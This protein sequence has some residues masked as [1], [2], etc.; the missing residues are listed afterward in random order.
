MRRPRKSG[1]DLTFQNKSKEGIRIRRK[2]RRKL[3]HGSQPEGDWPRSKEKGE[4][5]EPKK[6][7]EWK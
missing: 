5:V 2:K 4:K 1:T 7:K 3:D 6:K